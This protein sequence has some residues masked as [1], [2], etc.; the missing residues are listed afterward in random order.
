MEILWHVLGLELVPPPSHCSDRSIDSDF[1]NKLL[2]QTGKSSC[3][4]CWA[5]WVASG[6]QLEYWL[7][8][9]YRVCHVCAQH[10]W[11]WMAT[12]TKKKKAKLVTFLLFI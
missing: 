9:T 7:G 5:G 12:I 11:D 10:A 6:C 3:L 2:K 1:D 8:W 4:F